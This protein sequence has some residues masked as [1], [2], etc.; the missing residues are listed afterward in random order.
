MASTIINGL[1]KL[2]VRTDDDEDHLLLNVYDD[3]EVEEI[4]NDD[5]IKVLDYQELEEKFQIY[6]YYPKFIHNYDISTPQIKSLIVNKP[7]YSKANHHV[8]E[9]KQ[10]RRQQRKERDQLRSEKK[11]DRQAKKDR[12]EAARRERRQERKLNGQ[13]TWDQRQDRQ[14]LDRGQDRQELDWRQPRQNEAPGPARR[15][16]YI[17]PPRNQAPANHILP[18]RNQ[19]PGRALSPPANQVPD[20]DDSLV[21]RNPFD[22]AQATLVGTRTNDYPKVHHNR[23]NSVLSDYHKTRQNSVLSTD[24]N[25]YDTANYRPNHAAGADHPAGAVPRSSRRAN[26]L[27]YKF[28][29]RVRKSESPLALESLK[30]SSSYDATRSNMTNTRSKMNNFIKFRLNSSS[31]RRL[32]EQIGTYFLLIFFHILCV[33][34]ASHRK[35][36]SGLTP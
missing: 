32:S 36:R 4:N 35:C 18:P 31:S 34:R 30:T 24:S 22:P 8:K 2:S 15:P 3:T 5:L 11:D 33:K 17:L 27:A 14:E 20:L 6:K 16:N 29:H 13:E 12:K 9:M 7:I 1:N 28:F 10:L 23:Q 21:F 25:P 26:S 19:G